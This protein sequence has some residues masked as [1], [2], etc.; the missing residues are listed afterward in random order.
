MG[1]GWEEAG[2]TRCSRKKDQVSLMPSQQVREMLLRMAKRLELDFLK[3]TVLSN[4]SFLRASKERADST[5]P[6]N[7]EGEERVCG[8]RQ[9]RGKH[10]CAYSNGTELGEQASLLGERVGGKD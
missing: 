4:L 5:G 9:P 7:N 1:Q 8:G 6:I 2:C 3:I 10:L